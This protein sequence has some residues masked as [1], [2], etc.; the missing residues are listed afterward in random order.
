MDSCCHLN[1]TFLNGWQKIHEVSDTSASSGVTTLVDFPR[2]GDAV[3][4][5]EAQTFKSR[6]QT[7]SGVQLKTDI[8][9]M[10]RLPV[11]EADRTELLNLGC[12]GFEASLTQQP[13]ADGL[14]TLTDAALGE[15]TCRTA[16]Q[17]L[18]AANFD[19]LLVVNAEACSER[20]LFA[21]SRPESPRSVPP[22]VA[23]GPARGRVRARN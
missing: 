6:T 11:D 5:S 3:G 18:G 23:Q 7:L 10:A 13:S 8:G 2:L 20:E 15:Q 17:G 9:L 1:L 16:L 12:L 19:R 22:Q 14:Q 21:A 4:K